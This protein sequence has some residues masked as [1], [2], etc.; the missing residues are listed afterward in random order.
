MRLEKRN[1][2]I[3]FYKFLLSLVIVTLH[4]NWELCPQGYL[5]VESFFLIS[6][7][8]LAQKDVPSFKDAVIKRVISIY[9]IYVFALL[10]MMIVDCFHGYFLLFKQLPLYLS[11]LQVLTVKSVESNFVQSVSYLWFV[12]VYLHVIS[13]YLYMINRVGQKNVGLI[14]VVLLFIGIALLVYDSPSGGFNYTI[15][16]FNQPIPFGYLRGAVA[17]SF[18]YLCGIVTKITRTF[19]RSNNT[20]VY[21]SVCEILL[22][23]YIVWILFQ[24]VTTYYDYSYIVA[25]GLLVSLL[26]LRKGLLSCV[27]DF[28][29][30]QPGLARIVKSSNAVYFIHFL[31]TNEYLRKY[32]KYV[33][34]KHL[35]II[36]IMSVLSGIL[37]SMGNDKVVGKIKNHC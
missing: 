10:I 36:L 13:L 31:F 33:E 2:A 11:S 25:S 26:F 28:L 4:S 14:S 37:I 34:L 30:R 32:G 35:P 18:G 1:S 7:Y 3:D 15:E 20:Y 22:A 24:D 6:G 29:G 19:L 21:I 27:F 8:F 9:P 16:K 23:V 12:P 17:V 5:G